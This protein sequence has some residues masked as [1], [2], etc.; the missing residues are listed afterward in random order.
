MKKLSPSLNSKASFVP[1]DAPLGTIAIALAPESRMILHETV[2]RPLESNT[3][4]AFID[5]IDVINTK[6]YLSCLALL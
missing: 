1:V 6:K 5:L 4:I 3:C 2:G